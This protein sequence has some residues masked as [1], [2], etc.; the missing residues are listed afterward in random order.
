MIRPGMGCSKRPRLQRTVSGGR[1][2]GAAL[3]AILLAGT[4]ALFT[5]PAVGAEETAQEK[6]WS[7]DS[8]DQV[9]NVQENGDVVVDETLTVSFRGNFHF[10][11][12]DIPTGNY[13]GISEVEV[14][15]ANGVPLPEG[16]TPGTY[17]VGKQGDTTSIQVNFDLTDTA[18]VWTIHYRAKSVVLFG[19]ADDALEWYVFDAVSPVTIARARATVRLPGSVSSDVL[20]SKKTIDA[21][22]GATSNAYSPG[23][24]T[25]VFEAAD[26]LPYTRFWIKSGFPKGVVKHHWTARQVVSL[27]VPILGFFL[28]IATFLTVLLIWWRRGRDEPGQTYAKYVSEPPSDLSPGLVGAL[29]DERADTKEV[30][31]TIVDLARRGYLEITEGKGDGTSDKAGTIYTRLKPLD[32]LQGF[33]KI[34]AESLFDDGHPDQVTNSDLKNHFYVHVQPIVTQLY[35]DVT[36]AGLFRQNP[37]KTRKA[38]VWNGFLLLIVVAALSFILSKADVDGW[39]WLVAGALVSAIVM[40]SF[41]KYMP[42][43]TLKGAQEQKKWEA[44]RNYLL[45]LTRFQ[46]M[47]AARDKYEACLPYAVALGVEKQWTRRFEDLTVPSPTWYHPP[48]IISGGGT[49]PMHTGGSGGGLGGGL[50]GGIPKTGGGGGFSLDDVS[51]GLF[52]ALGKMSSVLTSSPSSSGGGSSRGAWGGGFSSGGGGFGGGGFSGGGGGGGGFRAG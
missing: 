7:I 10:F 38:W 35:E 15:D 30:I 12:H 32:D 5:G 21:G 1:L 37:N 29:I 48:V 19:P 11:A 31:A 50:G 34:V 2:W 18:G 43:R 27:V 33:E 14:R 20:M 49:G 23:P 42:G 44:F 51:D 25:I 9:L 45:D 3:L 40:W 6:T 17:G 24:S 22:A 16:D 28:P 47:E 41:A 36:A 13:G 4:V 8:V 46:D 39:G 26:V 52:G